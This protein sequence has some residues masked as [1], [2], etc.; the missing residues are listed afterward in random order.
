MKSEAQERGADW[1]ASVPAA[2]VCNVTH[3]GMMENQVKH[4]MQTGFIWGVYKG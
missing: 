3:T 2:K 1:A 4:D